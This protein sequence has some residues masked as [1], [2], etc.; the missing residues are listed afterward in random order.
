MKA[1]LRANEA[2]TPFSQVA[3]DLAESRNAQGGEPSSLADVCALLSAGDEGGSLVEFALIVPL[4][5]SLIMGMFSIGIALNNYI[6]LTNAVNAG[7]RAFAMSPAVYIGSSDTKITDPCAYAV[8]AIQGAANTLKSS[9]LGYTITW[10]AAS[11]GVA[12]PYTGSGSSTTPTCSGIS[13]ALGDT[14]QVQVTYP[15]V[16]MIY[17]FRPGNLNMA[18]TTTEYVQ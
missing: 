7:A 3:E 17:G 10:T 13:P 4:M 16:L 5:M 2:C 12:T 8:T 1:L 15:Y 14:V 6:V 11:T 18:A 9:S